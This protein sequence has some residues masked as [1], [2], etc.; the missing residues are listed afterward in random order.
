[1]KIEKLSL[2]DF[3]KRYGTSKKFLIRIREH[4]DD[5]IYY[6]GIKAFVIAKS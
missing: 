5:I 4:D 3:R 6:N 2:K 1:M